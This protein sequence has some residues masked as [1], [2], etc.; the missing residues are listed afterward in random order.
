[1][2]S[3]NRESNLF[4]SDKATVIII[5]GVTG[6]LARRK[7]IPSLFNNFKKERLPDN[8]KIVGVGR[9]EWSDD[10]M[11]EHAY[12]A[13]NEFASG[14]FDESIWDNFK[15][16]L[17]YALVNLPESDTYQNLKEHLD[18]I[19]DESANR[20]YYLS[21][22]PEFYADAVKNLGRYDMTQEDD[23][24]R[25]IVIEKPFGY[26]LD[27]AQKLNKVV[28][29]V[30]KESQVYRI[31]HYLGKET[32][33]NI[34]F[35]RFANTIFEPIWNRSHI[36]N[37]QVT[38][39][40]SVDVGTRAGYYDKSGVMRDMVQN[41]LLQLLSLIAME[42]P[43]S[44]DANALRNEKVKV[45]QAARPVQLKDTVRAQYDGYLDAEGV[46]P[47]SQTPTY[48][49]L[50]LFIDNWRWKDIPFYLRS[51]KALKTK[52]TQV[53]IQFKRPP[54]NIF[55]IKES[56]DTSRNMLSICIQPDEGMHLTIEAKVPDQQYAKSVDLEVHYEDAFDTEKLPD[57]YERLL[58]DAING[59]AALFIRSDEI[60]SAWKI[61]DSIIEGWQNDA[62]AP[63]MQTYDKGSWG[64]TAS[65][66]LL[67]QDEHI[68]RV[69]CLHKDDE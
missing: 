28:H 65:D 18:K 68:W 1:M 12:D 50:K 46:E 13:L 14:I 64:P 9:R 33:Q 60:E 55:E 52:T 40:E 49:G 36:S 37:V 47:D 31:D 20:L 19:E 15:Q 38:V 51:G 53:N 11:V 8:L 61:V 42:P 44:F 5:F 43:A 41:H 39:A 35:M 66:E 2:Q 7:L 16:T 10:K 32:A 59:D 21:I 34:L 63:P 30:F 45:L 23:A 26:D 3:R 4:M 58:L 69:S 22:A 27:T 54:N 17:S 48:A 25:R 6:D 29:S 56:D 67:A 24:W 62:S 57:A